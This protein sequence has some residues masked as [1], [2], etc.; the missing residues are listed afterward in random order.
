MDT[1]TGK[2]L[3]ILGLA[4]QGVALARF[5]AQVGARVVVS[6]LRSAA[7]LSDTLQQL[8]DLE[9]T[10][11]L[12]E[13]PMSLLENADVLAV[14][15]GVPAD[16]PLVRAARERGVAV[17]NDSQEFVRRAPTDV[18][19]ITGSAGKTTTTALTGVMGQVAGRRTWVGG[20]IGRPLIADLHKMAPGDMVV[21]ELSSFQLEMWQ[22]S[23]RIAA[24]LNITPNHLDRHKT[25]AA[26]R[27]AKANILRHQGGDDVAVL[28]ADDAGARALVP[29]VRGRLRFF[30]L[31]NAVRDGAF[32]RD[33]QVWLRN[34]H[35]TAVLPLSD[36]PLRGRHNV[37]NVLAAVTLA[38]A[39]D[40]PVEAMAAAIRSFRG[41][42]HRLEHVA[43]VRG[44][45]YVNDSIATAPERALAALAA[46]DEPIVLLA[47]GKDKEMVWDA[48][49]QQVCRQ[50]RH[51]VLFGALGEM[52]ARRLTAAGCRALT[53]VETL[54]EAVAAAAE[55]AVAGDV[56]LLSPG[57]TSF[58]AFKDFAE[59]GEAFRKLVQELV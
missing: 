47:G 58:D 37:L 36:I 23:P 57:G 35:E 38:D 53:R 16:A 50:V 25:M 9:I 6:D 51:V 26:Y 34:G 41:V 11:V 49:V 7:Q 5:A 15:G 4:R 28:S 44:V 18:I 59:R 40:I 20:N 1:L 10:Y 24:V 22:Q 17:T 31:E 29:L 43:T 13:H 55:T 8:A 39:V 14:S 33:G 3:V 19:G 21:Q 32:V 45:R 42:E 46:Y 27:D 52:L 56:V 48:W 30:S 2:T 12:G 54:A